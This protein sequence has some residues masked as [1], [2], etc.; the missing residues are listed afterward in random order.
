MKIIVKKIKKPMPMIKSEEED[1]IKAQINATSIFYTVFKEELE[2]KH[3]L[4][5]IIL[6]KND[7]LS[8]EH[9]YYFKLG[10]IL[11][12]SDNT[13]VNSMESFLF[14]KDELKFEE[15]QDEC[16]VCLENVCVKKGYF[17]CNHFIC[18]KCYNSLYDKKCCLCRSK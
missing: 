13:Y 8:V 11:L 12:T 2:K 17:N 7:I 1:K 6:N 15:K 3:N 14:F 18:K 4:K 16:H 5:N 9:I 10:G